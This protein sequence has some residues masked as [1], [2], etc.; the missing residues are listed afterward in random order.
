MSDMSD[1]TVTLKLEGLSTS[2][3]QE[4][5]GCEPPYSNPAGPSGCWHLASTLCIC[6]CHGRRR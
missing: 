1:G 3:A 2:M 5:V 6:A 4:F